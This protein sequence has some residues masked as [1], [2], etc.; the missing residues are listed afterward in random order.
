M[1]W[2][3]WVTLT[4]AAWRRRAADSRLKSATV[5][6]WVRVAHTIV[7]SNAWFPIG[8]LLGGKGKER[9]CDFGLAES[10]SRRV[11]VTVSPGTHRK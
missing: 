10:G 2:E 4:A 9:T 7:Y 1:I 3:A 6:V 11:P 8:G 5:V